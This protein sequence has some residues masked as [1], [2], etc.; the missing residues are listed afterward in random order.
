MSAEGYVFAEHPGA[1][2][3]APVLF[4]F[5]GTGG[6]EHQFLD[7]APQLLPGARLVAPR[8]DVSEGGALR[9]F[10]RLAEGRYDMADLA[11]A[12]GKMAGFVS[13]THRRIAA[14][15]GRRAPISTA[16]YRAVQFRPHALLLARTAH[17]L[18]RF[19]PRQ[20]AGDASACADHHGPKDRSA[21]GNAR[22]AGCFWAQGAAIALF[23]RGR[24]RLRQEGCSPCGLPRGQ[25]LSARTAR[26]VAAELHAHVGRPAGSSCRWRERRRPARLDGFSAKPRCGGT[27]VWSATSVAVPAV[28][29]S[30]SSV[31]G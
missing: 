20:R 7:L 26:S 1:A 2:P 17:Q 10:R 8:G 27:K 12:T 16:Q 4:L 22:L 30:A 25:R 24:P 15:A 11:R 29:S 14:G 6:N 5:H 21:P 19:R 13:R 23:S 3:D 28:V 31:S 18:I 9:Y